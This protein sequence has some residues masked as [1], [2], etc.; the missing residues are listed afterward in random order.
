[1]IKG[2]LP[3]LDTSLVKQPPVHYVIFKLL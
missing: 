2:E 1:M 3:V